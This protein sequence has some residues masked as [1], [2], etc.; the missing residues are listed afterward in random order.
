[1]RCEHSRNP[2]PKIIAPPEADVVLFFSSV[3]LLFRVSSSA[4]PIATEQQNEL[5]VET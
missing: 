5:I 2:P 1:M 4:M 3:D